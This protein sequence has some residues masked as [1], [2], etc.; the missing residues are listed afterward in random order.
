M[1]LRKTN[2]PGGFAPALSDFCRDQ[3]SAARTEILAQ[4]EGLIDKYCFVI[5]ARACALD[6]SVNVKGV[7]LVIA[8]CMAVCVTALAAHEL[9]LVSHRH[10]F[11]D[12]KARLKRR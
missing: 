9:V 2:I 1:C 6:R 7:Q 11:L 12:A 4:Y 8:G 10:I 5:H 3:S